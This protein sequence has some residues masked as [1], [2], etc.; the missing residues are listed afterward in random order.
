MK[1]SSEIG[2]G[3]IVYSLGL[4]SDLH[5]TSRLDIAELDKF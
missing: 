4:K 2:L 5:P 3:Q 1:I